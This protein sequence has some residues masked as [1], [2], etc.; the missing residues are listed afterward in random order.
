MIGGGQ[1]S[2]HRMV[3][4][5]GGRTEETVKKSQSSRNFR[6]AKS[7][8]LVRNTKNG[9]F[10]VHHCCPFNAIDPMPMGDANAAE[11]SEITA[12]ASGGGVF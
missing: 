6:G 8:F 5:L 1:R 2:A 4:F 7:D 9:K 3:L 12:I 10:H 11:R